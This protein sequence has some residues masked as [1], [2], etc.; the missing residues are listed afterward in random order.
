MELGEEYRRPSTK[1]VKGELLDRLDPELVDPRGLIASAEN[2]TPFDQLAWFSRVARFWDGECKPIIAHAWNAGSHCWLFLTHQGDKMQSLSNWYSMIFRPVFSG[3]PDR[4]VVAAMARRLAKSNAIA[5]KLTLS[6]VPSRDGSSDML[7]SA[8]A[9]NGWWV[10]R[11]TTSVSWT[12]NVAGK[13]FDEYWS[14]RPGELRSTYK[15]K[16]KKA[17]IVCE[18]HTV[19][20]DD[21]WAEYDSVYE[22]SWKPA[23]GTIA[24]LKD[25]A[26]TESALGA[27][28]LGFARVDGQAIAAQLW[29]VVN[30]V[31]YI[32][33][34]AYRTD[35]D[36]VS[37]GSILS[38]DMFRH[39]I[40]IDKVSVIDFG[41]GN[42]R[43]K[44]DWMDRCDD[45]DTIQLFK[46]NS[47]AGWMGAARA[48]I[49][50]LAGKGRNA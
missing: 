4:Q 32:H 46:K 39:V 25:M 8:F 41:T 49:S 36:A 16:L 47:P 35:F 23:E 33:K 28:R 12:I 29:I 15:R 43:Y 17:Q 26:E 42:D 21:L 5:P 7:V 50:S 44:A 34:L 9:A 13:T 48:W 22:D 45:L 24:F 6:T 2:L 10:F 27:L 1:W 18:V 11:S 20:S 40:D 31:A 38:H 3:E 14:E 30:G 37:P 19:L